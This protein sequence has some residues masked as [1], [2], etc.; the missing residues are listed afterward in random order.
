MTILQP[1]S[2]FPDLSL[3]RQS[4][5]HGRH[6]PCLEVSGGIYHLTFHLADSIPLTE[7]AAWREL[8]QELRERALRESRELTEDERRL[9]R[10]CHDERIERFLSCG[11]GSCILR[12]SRAAD[13]VERTLLFG[14]GRD[15]ALHEYTIMPNH[16]HVIA[17]GF[18]DGGSLRRVLAQWKSIT[19]HRINTALGRQGD[20][21]MKDAYSHFIRSSAEY[22]VQMSYVWMNPESAG[23][24]EGFRRRRFVER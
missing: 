9:L 16:L 13:E 22:Q 5:V 4:K 24:K 1:T 15:Y 21:W 18:S 11:C 17:G 7:L 20:V 14:N 19:A 12:D 8:R 23:L 2:S 6:L 10:A 3:A